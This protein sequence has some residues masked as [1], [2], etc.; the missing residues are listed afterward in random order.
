ML[1]VCKLDC[2]QGAKFLGSRNRAIVF[3][4]LDSGLRLSE[5]AGMKLVDIDSNKGWIKVRGKGDK[6]RVARIGKS[7]Q[8]ALWTYLT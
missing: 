5:L 7:A 8:K 3:V 4:L 1:E 6:E 2:Q